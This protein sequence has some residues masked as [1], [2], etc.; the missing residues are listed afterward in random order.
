MEDRQRKKRRY[1]ERKWRSGG[2]RSD[3]ERNESGKVRRRQEERN[4]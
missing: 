1:G 3:R 2:E 4:W